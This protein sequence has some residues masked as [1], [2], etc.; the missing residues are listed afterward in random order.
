MDDNHCHRV[1]G[2]DRWDEGAR[3]DAWVIL[4]EPHEEAGYQGQQGEE[5]D[6]ADVEGGVPVAADE[7]VGHAVADVAVAV[8]G[9]GSDVEDG[10]DDAQTHH[11][12]AGLAARLPQGPAVVEDGQED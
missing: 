9:N 1:P 2:T 5:T 8:N 11:K 10:A 4:Q 7:V 3:V 12:G 6:K